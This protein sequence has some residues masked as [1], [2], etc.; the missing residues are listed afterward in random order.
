MSCEVEEK[1]FA[2]ALLLSSQFIF[3]TRG[4][5]TEQSIDDLAL[6]PMMANR[7]RMAQ[8]AEQAASDDS[9]DEAE[10][11][12]EFYKVFP[13]FTWVLRDLDMD[14]KHLTPKAY[15]MQ[16][17][18]E[19]RGKTDEA[20]YKNGIRR[21]VKE[22]FGGEANLNCF[23]LTKPSDDDAGLETIDQMQE[24]Q[25]TKQFAQSCSDF[26]LQLKM[27]FAVKAI[28]H[29]PLTGN[30]L[31]NLAME[32]VDTLNQ[33]ETLYI[34]PTFEKVVQIE[35]ERFSEKLFES[36]KDK[37]A[38]DCGVSRMPFEHEELLKR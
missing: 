24:S 26:I 13:Q 21:A 14:F 7:I 32:Y 36:I 6:L 38:K 4:H 33:N 31:L 35:S 37:I 25:L 5:I 9:S 28:N 29:R 22:Y 18:E 15:L 12:G 2:L 20:R 1:L 17:L 19:S 10:H 3:N 16:G 8:D 30:M 23:A 11:T 27:N 34:V